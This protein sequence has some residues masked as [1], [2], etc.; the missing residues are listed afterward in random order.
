MK[1]RRRFKGYAVLERPD[2]ALAWGTFRPTEAE[3]RA[4]WEKWNPA[5]E[6]VSQQSTVV[7]ISVV[8]GLPEK[9]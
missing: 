7:P 6:G 1:R 8:V 2:G 3:A 4:I 9:S 5:V